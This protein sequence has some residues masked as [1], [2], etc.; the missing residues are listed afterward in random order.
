MFSKEIETDCRYCSNGHVLSDED[1]CMCDKYGL[2]KRKMKCSHFKYDPLK[3]IPRKKEKL[4][5]N[6]TI[7]DFEIQ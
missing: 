1:D 4:E 2:I 6:F 5:D 7:S 3:R